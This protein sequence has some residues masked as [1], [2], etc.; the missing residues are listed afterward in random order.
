MWPAQGAVHGVYDCVGRIPQILIALSGCLSRT[1][2][3]SVKNVLE[4]RVPMP[5]WTYSRFPS[6]SSPFCVLSPWSLAWHLGG[7][8]ACGH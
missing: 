1:H 2:S 6:Y 7:S 4:P 8:E 5:T 3:V